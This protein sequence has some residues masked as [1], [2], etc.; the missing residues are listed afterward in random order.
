MTQGR[1]VPDRRF[2]NEG[3]E[4]GQKWARGLSA[5]HPHIQALGRFVQSHG[6]DF[7]RFFNEAEP[8]RRVAEA[9]TLSERSAP[10]ADE[11]WKDAIGNDVPF[12]WNRIL[13]SGFL[14]GFCDGAVSVSR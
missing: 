3:I 10:E 2:Y 11:F 14:R 6:S 9:L 7:D 12:W 5:E 1:K 4:A 8:G 13:D